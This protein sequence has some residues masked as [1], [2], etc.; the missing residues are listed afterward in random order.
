MPNTNTKQEETLHQ[1]KVKLWEELLKAETSTSKHIIQQNLLYAERELRAKVMVSFGTLAGLPKCK[2]CYG[3]GFVL[4]YK[5]GQGKNE[6]GSLKYLP[7]ACTCA[8]GK[9]ETLDL[10]TEMKHA[11]QWDEK[12]KAIAGATDKPGDNTPKLKKRVARKAKPNEDTDT[13]RRGEEIQ[14]VS[15]EVHGTGGQ[16]AEDIQSKPKK[17]RS[18]KKPSNTDENI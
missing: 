9:L 13:G 1:L 7:H 11:I 10:R 2:T 8:V 3:K 15:Q 12:N 16:G 18:P 6:D 17:K 4:R 14:S 5:P